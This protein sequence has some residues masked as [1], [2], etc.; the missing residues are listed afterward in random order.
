MYLGV[1]AK[2]TVL[3]ILGFLICS[4]FTIL[5]FDPILKVLG[6]RHNLTATLLFSMVIIASLTTYRALLA[7]TYRTGKFGE[8]TDNR[9]VTI[10]EANPTHMLIEF[11]VTTVPIQRWEAVLKFNTEM[12][13]REDVDGGLGPP[14]HPKSPKKSMVGF[15]DQSQNDPRVY[16]VNPG[17]RLTPKE[18]V[19]LV[20]FSRD[21]I[22]VLNDCRFQGESES[23]EEGKSCVR[24]EVQVIDRS[25]KRSYEPFPLGNYYSTRGDGKGWCY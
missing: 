18:S 19:Y 8:P 14:G 13:L 1:S 20:F 15:S 24:G 7:W 25:G 22:P 23:F 17:G 11:G 4:A 10:H 5:F 2:W 3:C 21:G 16:M 6:R 12:C 9:Y